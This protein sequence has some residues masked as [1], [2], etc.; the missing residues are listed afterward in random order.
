[1]YSPA[2][3]SSAFSTVGSI[4]KAV[5]LVVGLVILAMAGL[6]IYNAVRVSQG[7]PTSSMFGTAVTTDQTPT[8]VNGQ[9]EMIVPAGSV[10][11]TQ[12][13]DYGVQLWMYIK[14]WDANFGKEKVVLLRQ[15]PTNT[16]TT[17]PRITL[18]PTDNSL[19][20]SVSIFPSSTSAGSSTPSAANS[21][22]ATG[23]VFTCTVE[24][25]P[26]QSWFSVSTTVFQRNLDIY[27]NGRLVK[28][29]VLPGVPKPAVG[30]V[31]IGSK[32]SGFS[33]QICN[34]HMYPNALTPADAMAFYSGG[35]TCGA[36]TPPPSGTPANT[37][38]MKIFGYTFTFGVLDNAGK[39]IKSYTF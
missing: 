18:H 16:A 14:D 1:M 31:R 5:V 13:S 21:T 25:V 11:L 38:A 8:A 23:D 10:P 24:N 19:N 39:Q 29:C 12:G 27:I 7:M 4:G 26:L 34:V 9:D 20:V 32:T 33:G 30:D 17:S 28:S 2:P 37:T 36:S 22:N 15:D 6:F 35:T 3:P